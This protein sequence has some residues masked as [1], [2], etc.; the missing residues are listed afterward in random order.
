METKI[1][2]NFIFQSLYQVTI[3]ILPIITIPVVSKALGPEGLGIWNYIYSIVTYFL[4]SAGLGVNQFASREI[5]IARNDKSKLSQKFWELEAFSIVITLVVLLLFAL[6]CY[7][8]NYKTYFAISSLIIISN[9]F[10]ITWFFIGIED[11]KKISIVNIIIKII[12]FLL[13]MIFVNQKDDLFNYFIIQSGSILISQLSLWLFVSKYISFSNV[14]RLDIMGCLKP[15][16]RYFLPKIAGQSFLNINKTMLGI[17]GTFSAVGLFSNSYSVVQMVATLVSTLG[18][19]MSPR[20]SY[21]FSNKE[22]DKAIVLLNKSIQILFFLTL[23][24]MFGVASVAD[25]VQEWFFGNSFYGIQK[26]IVLMSPLIV[27]QPFASSVVTMYLIPRNRIKAYNLS[28][29]YA[30]LFSIISSGI[31]IPI[32]GIY[33]AL[34]SI[35]GGYLIMVTLRWR[36]L[37]KADGFLIQRSELIK[38]LLASIIMFIIVK[39]I[40]ALKVNSVLITLIQV[41]VGIIVYLSILIAFKSNV[42][43]EGLSFLRNILKK[44]IGDDVGGK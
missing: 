1:L 24:L 10:D 27:M 43:L 4:I 36:E 5:A 35:N 18:N 33:G 40:G 44:K 20:M 41:I 6:F 29:I 14:S 7:F 34:I 21:L 26:I 9:F 19:V 28:V 17:L 25:S 13:I 11:F 22:S 15:S 23:P 39:I 3:I 2:K 31:L 30:S 42:L 8:S 32:F 38:S 37:V 16:L 12:S